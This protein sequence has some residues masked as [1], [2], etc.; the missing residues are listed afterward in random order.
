MPLLRAVAFVGFKQFSG[1]PP[2]DDSLGD[3][4]ILMGS[5]EI[6]ASADSC[7]T[8]AGFT[9]LQCLSALLTASA[10]DALLASLQLEYSV[11][12]AQNWSNLPA[13]AFPARPGVFLGEFSTEQLGLV[14]AILMEAASL[15]DNEGFDEME[16]TLNAD[17]YIGTV[18][19]DTKSGYSSYNSKFAF[20]DTPSDTGTWQLY[21]GGHH[22]AFT[23]TYADGVLTGAT[24]SF[25]GIEPFPSFD[26]NGP[27]TFHCCRNGMPLRPC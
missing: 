5:V 14:K 22:F 26:M 6:P 23:N 9:R 21:Y 20:L 24:P 3:T 1:G 4:S 18:S 2:T 19:D 16:Q 27:K 17:D 25:S 7:G 13:G 12:E 10:S 8:E 15:T 11:A